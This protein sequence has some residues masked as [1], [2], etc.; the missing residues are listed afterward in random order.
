M[1]KL[2]STV[3]PAL[4][5]ALLCL[6]VALS[7]SQAQ[8]LDEDQ[9]TEAATADITATSRTD[10]IFD[11]PIVLIEGRN[12]DVGLEQAGAE[13]LTGTD[14]EFAERMTQI[15]RYEEEI[16]TLELE[17]GAWNE[18]LTEGLAAIGLLHQQQNNHAAAIDAFSRAMHLNRIH[19]GL[20]S[21]Q[22]VPLIEALVSSYL[23]E[24]KWAEADNF[25][26]YLFYVQN[27]AYGAGDPRMVSVLMNLAHWNLTAFNAGYGEALGIR[28]LNSY[29]LFA[30]ATQIV[31][32]HFGKLDERYVNALKDMA[33]S[34]YLVSRNQKL[35]EA[36]GRPE[37]RDFQSMYNDEVRKIQPINAGGYREGEVALLSI[38]D[39]YG[40]DPANAYEHAQALAQL[41]DWYLLFDRG[42]T[43]AEQYRQAY[44]Q[45]QALSDAEEK[46]QELF[47][48]IVL[49]PS[50]SEG[51]E[52]LPSFLVEP[53]GQTAQ[54]QSGYA[55]VSLDVNT[56]G[57]AS[58]VEILTAENESNARAHMLLRRNVR[59]SMFRPQIVDGEPVTSSANL[60][61]Y[62]YRY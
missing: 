27:K 9:L 46:M 44:F 48:G 17:G 55:D 58:N 34:A 62:Y 47:G 20:D 12:P 31:S 40:E 6:P 39:Y 16:G 37:Y 8:D 23:A 28:L 21:L 57:A 49:L 4:L 14:T 33:G 52:A 25:Q 42:R 15:G 60:L 43:A 54:M 45:V 2:I 5:I 13:L 32:V 24:D 19:F 38:V 1:G 41:G 26:A 36:A 7:W 51:V 50:F 53:V 61:R 35:I 56:Y 3:K 30:A 29:R 10:L 59:A 18:N 11:K 22:Q